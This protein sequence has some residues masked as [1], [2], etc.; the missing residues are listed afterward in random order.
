MN[1]HDETT[2]PAC[3]DAS[4]GPRGLRLPRGWRIWDILILAVLLGGIVGLGVWAKSPWYVMLGAGFN[5]IG[6]F[7]NVKTSKLF[8]PFSIG[9]SACYL[10][11]AY[12]N[13]LYGEMATTVLLVVIALISIVNWLRADDV[14]Q[15]TY[16]IRRLEPLSLLPMAV[17]AVVAF[18]AYGFA[19]R[20]IGSRLPFLSAGT[21]VASICAYYLASRRVKLQWVLWLVNN[22]IYL[23]I[24]VVTIVEAKQAGEIDFLAELPLI[25]QSVVYVALNV[26]GLINWHVEWNRRTR[27]VEPADLP[28][29]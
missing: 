13:H 27:A 15:S 3:N 17:L 26:C 28:S 11:I 5:I 20:A 23:S 2:A 1:T 22:A 16:E 7:C 10:Y 24:W 18:L 9:Y 8:F 29:N 21:A 4:A 19:L 25:A 12:S 14:K 6:G